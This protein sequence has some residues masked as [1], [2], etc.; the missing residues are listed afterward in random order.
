M[1]KSRCRSIFL[2]FWYIFLTQSMTAAFGGNAIL[3]VSSRT[4]DETFCIS[5][6]SLAQRLP[7]SLEDAVPSQL[8]DLSQATGCTLQEF[9]QH[10]SFSDKTV[11]LLSGKCTSKQKAELVQQMNGRNILLINTTNYYTGHFG[12][13]IEL[14]SVNVTVASITWADYSQI[15]LHKRPIS[16]K[17]FAPPK[18]VW[19]P[20]MIVLT[21]FST[22][23][24]MIGAGWAAC[25]ERSTLRN[26]TTSSDDDKIKEEKF[27][28]LQAES[29]Q[30]LMSIGVVG[31]WF[32][33]TCVLIVLLHFFYPYM[34]YIFIA[35]FSLSGSYS[36]YQCLLPACSLV[37]PAIYEIQANTVPC[38]KNK[39]KL[40]DLVLYVFSLSLGIYWAVHRNASYSWAIQDLLGASLC[41]I[42]LQSL[43]LQSFKTL[44]VL[45]LLFLIYDIFFVF[46][47]PFITQNGD[48]V[49]MKIATG[50]STAMGSDQY[51][52]HESESVQYVATA[53]P[54]ESL[55]LMFL[56]PLMSRNPLARC[57]EHLYS[58]LGFGDVIIPGFLVCHNA[59]FDVR[60]GTKMVY[61]LASSLGYLCGMIF[62][63][64]SLVLMN[65]GQPALLYLVP[66][67]LITTV[68]LAYIRGDLP[69][70][71][72]D[73]HSQANA[74]TNLTS[75][76]KT[77]EEEEDY[78]D[79]SENGDHYYLISQYT[80]QEK[81]ERL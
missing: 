2:L 40:R 18:P 36:L 55:P 29:S 78:I 45:L 68:V 35:I 30:N 52:A 54:K 12:Q 41:I 42:C 37:L 21:V 31:V 71:L 81:K 53:Q 16:L 13:T 3:H 32:L 69:K 51:R 38:F 20:N 14:S 48:S 19:D 62:C 4:K 58:I 47:T 74:Q 75:T 66:G 64:V 67:T 63:M 22:A 57:N 80:S 59:I 43:R 1:K 61:Y 77:S 7:S 60:T 46:V 76:Q 79:D 11:A 33:F 26:L 73:S 65:S 34:V 9:H 49:M 8:L 5:Y 25:V 24:V 10:T 72:Q 15:F 27:S 23:F 44:S 56:I 28:K 50:G 70:M 17:L 39:V 6:D